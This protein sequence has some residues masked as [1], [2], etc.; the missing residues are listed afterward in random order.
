MLVLLLATSKI[1]AV[2]AGTLTRPA[3]LVLAGCSLNWPACFV[4]SMCL[5]LSLLIKCFFLNRYAL[6][7]LLFLDIYGSNPPTLEAG[8]L[9]KCSCL[10]RALGVTKFITIIAMFWSHFV[11]LLKSDLDVQQTHLWGRIH[12]TSFSSK[13]TNQPN[14]LECY[15]KLGRKSLP[16]TNALTYWVCS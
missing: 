5:L 6:S 15:I 3:C 1:L 12:K 2:K 9:N 8:S 11:V 10:A 4:L 7:S 14:K 16:E 13:L